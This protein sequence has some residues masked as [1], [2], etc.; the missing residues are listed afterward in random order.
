MSADTPSP[1]APGR[2]RSEK[3]R[4]AILSATTGLLDEIGFGAMTIEAVAARAGSSK[5][6]VYRWWP[7]KAGLAM[8]AFMAEVSPRVAFP[9]TGSA[10]EDFRQQVRSTARLFVKGRI[11]HVLVG[12]VSEAQQDGELRAAFRE[13]YLTPRRDEGHRALRRGIERGELR[14]DL[15]GEVLMDQIYGALYFRLLIGNGPLD[16]RFTDALVEQAFEGVV[17]TADR[18][19]HRPGESSS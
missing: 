8:D 3:A 17:T 16:R 11:R 5:A 4:D 15:D 1:R 6:T 14:G 9:N 7:N 2:P 18:L 10:V 19:P 12:V 13:R